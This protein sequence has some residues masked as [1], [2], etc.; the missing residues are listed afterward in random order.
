M[1]DQVINQMQIIIEN[2]QLL[3]DA[4]NFNN[5]CNIF[6][7]SCLILAFIYKAISNSIGDIF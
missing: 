1:E 4:I 6:L 7:I 3:I 2:Q 5:A